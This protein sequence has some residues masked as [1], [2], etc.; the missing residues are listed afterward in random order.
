[1]YACSLAHTILSPPHLLCASVA[2]ARTMWKR[3]R[4][5]CSLTLR[6]SLVPVIS[7]WYVC[8]GMGLPVCANVLKFELPF[9]T[10]H[11]SC[12]RSDIACVFALDG[13]PGA[14]HASIEVR[15]Y[16]RERV[17]SQGTK[18]IVEPDTVIRGDFA[19]VKIGKNCVVRRGA[20][21]RPSYKKMKGNVQVSCARSLARL[22]A[23]THTHTH[24]HT[25]T[26]PCTQAHTRK[27]TRTHAWVHWSR[28]HLHTHTRSHALAGLGAVLPRIRA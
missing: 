8:S 10:P 14:A 6:G 22:H 18:T 13:R 2:G 16:V 3:R 17:A 5:P 25:H 19:K 26:S 4:V 11:S 15:W 21:I 20:V 12:A 28:G 9:A 1:M 27:D 23:R 24:T 7:P